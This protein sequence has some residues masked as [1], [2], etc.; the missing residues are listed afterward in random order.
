[1]T[2]KMTI[3]SKR[4]VWVDFLEGLGKF[5]NHLWDELGKLLGLSNN[6]QP[7][8]PVSNDTTP[9]HYYKQPTQKISWLDSPIHLSSSMTWRE[10]LGGFGK[11]LVIGTGIV[12]SI[13]GMVTLI[14]KI[15]KKYEIYD[16]DKVPKVKANFEASGFPPD[17]IKQ[18]QYLIIL[19]D[20]NTKIKDKFIDTILIR[21]QIDPK[22][23]V[24]FRPPTLRSYVDFEIAQLSHDTG[25]PI[26]SRNYLDFSE[27]HDEERKG[28]KEVIGPIRAIAP[29]YTYIP[30]ELT[31]FTYQW[32]KE[33]DLENPNLIFKENP[34][35]RIK[36]SKALNDLKKGNSIFIDA[37]IL[38]KGIELQQNQVLFRKL[39]DQGVNVIIT[40]TV[41]KEYY[42]QQES[43]YEDLKNRVIER[44]PLKLQYKTTIRRNSSGHIQDIIW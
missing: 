17:L 41:K 43:L 29:H 36:T 20:L 33:K 16:M 26:I 28:N 37:Q 7:Q 6:S 31:P 15:A 24:L 1:M 42:D 3:E 21:D 27:F 2:I 40:E 9:S 13:I 32:D 14:E 30:P 12:V 34:N 4:P 25:Y 10:S 39:I 19:S 11:G 23:K 8:L 22:N 38:M 35:I 18:M 5:G 44:I